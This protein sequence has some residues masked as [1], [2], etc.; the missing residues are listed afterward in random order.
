MHRSCRGGGERTSAVASGGVTGSIHSP[1]IR[2]PV[3]A[4]R[5]PPDGRRDTAPP[6]RLRPHFRQRPEDQTAPR[7]LDLAHQLVVWS[8]GVEDAG[9]EQVEASSAVPLPLGCLILLAVPFDASGAVLQGQAG[10]HG[11]VVAALP[12]RE[13]LQSGQRV[14]LDGG[15]ATCRSVGRTGGTSS[16]RARRGGWR[17]AASWASAREPAGDS[18]LYGA[19][20]RSPRAAADRARLRRTSCCHRRSSSPRAEPPAVPVEPEL[21]RPVPPV[22]Q[23]R[24]GVPSCPAPVAAIRH[25]PGSRVRVPVPASRC[26]RVPPPALVRSRP[27]QKA[28]ASGRRRSIALS[29][30]RWFG[31]ARFIQDG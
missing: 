12:G 8:V 9:A 24:R 23:H 13:A 16:R 29:T 27:V 31:S 20:C 21:R 18:A 6:A 22:D 3:P 14:G 11:V 2:N 10:A 25:G 5:Y 26:A 28:S 4:G 17:P 19:C 1:R 15:P 30:R 7:R